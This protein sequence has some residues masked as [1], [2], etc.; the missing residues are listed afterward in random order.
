MAVPKAGD[1]VLPAEE[2]GEIE[3]KGK[4]DAVPVYAASLEVDERSTP[5]APS[6]TAEA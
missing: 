6:L 5:G 3:L 2:R 4:S 1:V